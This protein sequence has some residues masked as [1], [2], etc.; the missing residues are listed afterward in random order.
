M[1][2]H[3]TLMVAFVSMATTLLSTSVYADNGAVNKK[4]FQRVFYEQS[5]RQ[6]RSANTAYVDV[7]RIVN[8][9]KIRAKLAPQVRITSPLNDAVVALGEGSIGDG[10]TNGTGFALNIEVMT[11][12]GKPIRLH[13]ATQDPARPGIRHVDALG[14]VNPDFP[15]LFVFFDTDLITPDGEIIRKNTNLAP[16]FN[17]AGTDDTPG[18]G[19]T[20]WVGWHVLESLP[21]GVKKFNI[22]TA[23]R[24]KAGRI[25][26]DKITVKVDKKIDSGNA[27]T[28]DPATFLGHG[29]LNANGP[30]VEIIAPRTPSAIAV[31]DQ[32]ETPTN[33]T[34]ALSF[35]Q[36]NV[37]DLANAGI[38]ADE[39]GDTVTAPEFG[40]GVILDPTQLGKGDN[41]NFPGFY[42]AFDVPLRTPTGALIAAGVNLAPVFNTLGSEV[43]PLTGAV[44]V[45]A[46]W[47]VGGSLILEP[48]REFVTF[49]AKV[50]DNA[51]NAGLAER[52][53]RISQVAGGQRLTPAPRKQLR[54]KSYGGHY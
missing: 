49:S 1:M 50:T 53:F 51:G 29:E 5:A 14:E 24:D 41:R 33:E 6:H 46:D 7:I 48:G 28:P 12:D 16:L 22:T 10:S 3:N 27:L 39:V 20:A 31:G 36:V 30:K 17:I 47:V 26:F 19:V 43:D 9:K 54:K 25:G 32:L 4:H 52:R 8:N 15:G 11:R 23:V 38:A 13:E 45:I 44:R 34:A 18:K 40:P 42:F 35:I 2:K 21:E 37:L